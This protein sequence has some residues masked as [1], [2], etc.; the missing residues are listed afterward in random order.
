VVAHLHG[1]VEEDHQAVPGEALEGSFVR[2]DQAPHL[3]VVLAEHLHHLLGL[4]ALRELRESA[5][6]GEDHAHVAAV[7][8]QHAAVLGDQLG[9]LGREEALQSFQSREL[10][11]L[12]F[13]TALE[14]VAP[15]RKLLV[16]LA[17]AQQRTYA[18]QQLRGVDGLG[19]EV[20]RAGLD[21]LHALLGGIECGHHDDGQEPGLF[22]LA[23][24][25]AHLVTAHP[26]HHHVEQ[27]QIGALLL[28]HLQ[29]FGSGS[30]AADVEVAR[31]QQVDQQPHVV[32]R[33]VDHEDL[34]A[35]AQAA[36][37]ARSRKART[38]WVISFT[39]IGLA[40]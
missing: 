36:P 4:G 16:K 1:V 17:N 40:W 23:D 21:S 6:V 9:H 15:L 7:R 14:G 22:A 25:A 37:P 38:S 29:R 31:G 34:A 26:G 19:E 2:R 18:R 8:L 11:D 5:Q 32:G 20:V 27:H 3:G 10:L 30:G 28:E 35:R 13:D 24:P 33:V 39:L 12:L